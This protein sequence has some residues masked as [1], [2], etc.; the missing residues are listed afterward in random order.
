MVRDGPANIARVKPHTT[1][2][3]ALA[4]CFML[5][6]L[7]AVGQSPSAKDQA[8]A[9]FRQGVAAARQGAWTQAREAF[10]RAHRLSPHPLVLFNLAG[11]Q[12]RTGRLLAAAANY[13][14]VLQAR[15]A[16][17][18]SHR[19]AAQSQL[20]AIEA[21]IPRL[22][23]QIQ[24]LRH[25]DRVILDRTRLYPNELELEQWVDPGQHE[26]TVFRQGTEQ[27]TKRLRLSEGQR[28]TVMLRL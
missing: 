2:A 4:A 13:R 19:R 17:A 9:Q 6:A 3:A 12:A 23:I 18:A 22:R 21:R 1:R 25:D 11:A 8:G 5:C 24:G 16:V 20:S 26:L 14:R 10:Q 28:K 27:Q 15:T 7:P